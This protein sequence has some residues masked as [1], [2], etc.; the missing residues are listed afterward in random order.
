MPTEAG[1]WS[2]II[3]CFD[4]PQKTGRR[5]IPRINQPARMGR[6]NGHSL[7]TRRQPAQGER[8]ARSGTG[9]QNT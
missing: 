6:T 9:Q 5:V 2:K 4:K 3:V 7:G 8:T 1:R